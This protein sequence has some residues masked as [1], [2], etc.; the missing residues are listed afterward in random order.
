VGGVEPNQQIFCSLVDDGAAEIPPVFL[1]QWRSATTGS[2]NVEAARWRVAIKEVTDGV[3][4]VI[5]AFEVE[6]SVD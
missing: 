4:V 2:R 1:T 6:E 3:L 5:S